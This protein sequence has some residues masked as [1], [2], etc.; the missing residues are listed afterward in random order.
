MTLVHGL[1]TWIFM[2]GTFLSENI[3]LYIYG[4][5][6]SYLLL[7]CDHE[8]YSWTHF[9]YI[10]NKLTGNAIQYVIVNKYQCHGCIIER[11]VLFTFPICVWIVDTI[12]QS[13][14]M[15]KIIWNVVNVCSYGTSIYFGQIIRIALIC[16]KIIRHV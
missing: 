7:K 3:L 13:N 5:L 9:Q 6:S 16:S 12:A 4:W 14:I 10:G 11:F 8:H 1:I 15:F 2:F